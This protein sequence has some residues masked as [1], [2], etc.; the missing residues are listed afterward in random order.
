MPLWSDVFTA[1]ACEC[2]V[3]LYIIIC[4]RLLHVCS[5]NSNGQFQGL[6]MINEQMVMA[7]TLF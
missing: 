1:M 7:L 5:F 4:V 2:H 6:K 3:V